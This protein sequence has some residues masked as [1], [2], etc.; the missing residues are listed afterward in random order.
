MP[1]SNDNKPRIVFES[2]PMY[3]FYGLW[4]DCMSNP[5]MAKKALS[6][7]DDERLSKIADI[8][9]EKG[10]KTRKITEDIHKRIGKEKVVD[11]KGLM[12]L[13]RNDLD[14]QD[15]YK[16]ALVLKPAFKAYNDFF[17]KNKE[18]INKN[19][20][21]MDKAQIAYS[22]DFDRLYKCFNIPSDK[23]CTC[24]LNPFPKDKINDGI[25]NSENFSM[26]YSFNRVE[27]ENNY[28]ENSDILKRKLSTPFHEATH[29]MFNNSQLKKDIENEN[30]PEMNS[31]LHKMI[32]KFEKKGKGDNKAP[33]EELKFYAVGAINEAFAACSTALYNEKTTGKPAANDD[34]WYH[35][36]KVANDLARQ[37]YPSF[38][39]YVSSGKAFDNT[40]FMK[41]NTSIKNDELKHANNQEATEQTNVSKRGELKGLA[42][43]HKVPYKPQQAKNVDIS[44]LKYAKDLHAGGK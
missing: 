7:F 5:E 27:N 3:S 4:R 38:K 34:E 9:P 16:F 36:W 37:M 39:E 2:N 22:D 43:S 12:T 25:S 41:V 6:G 33:R 10:T 35:G 29:F 44:L 19:I 31:V 21:A 11:F 28:V 42:A 30:N 26:D 23:K 20:D 15:V 17:E 24:F 32:S 1:N 8:I 14:F 40:F 13:M 18:N